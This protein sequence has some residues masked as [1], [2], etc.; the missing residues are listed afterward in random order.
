MAIVHNPESDYSRENERWNTT[1][2]HGGFNANGFEEYPLMV[3]KAFER[4]NGKVMCGDPL[5]TVGDAEGEAFSRS[6][7]LVV[8]NDEERDKAVK[9]GWSFGPDTAIEKYE[10]DMRSIAEITA[11]RHFA[12][13]GSSDLAKAEAKQADDAT[14]RQVPEVPEKR[15]RGRPRKAGV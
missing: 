9:A 10:H 2:Q 11:Q 3:F 14:H 12:E 6:C 7:Q 8:R 15:K 1:K 4:D 13:Q 5:A